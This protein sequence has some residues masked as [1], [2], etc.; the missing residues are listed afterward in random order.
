VIKDEALR[1]LVFVV[2]GRGG[3]GEGKNQH[4]ISQSG[5]MVHVLT[6]DVNIL[7]IELRCEGEGRVQLDNHLVWLMGGKS[8]SINKFLLAYLHLY[9]CD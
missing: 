4:M 3:G 1:S 8:N 5:H 7:T 6:P 2:S 9:N